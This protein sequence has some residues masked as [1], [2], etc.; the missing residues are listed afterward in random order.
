[1]KKLVSLVSLSMVA[2]LFVMTSCGSKQGTPSGIVKAMY[3]QLQKGNYEKAIEIM[4][5][6]ATDKN[7]KADAEQIKESVK[8]FA[9][10]AQESIEEKEGI[11]SFEI[12]KETVA[13]DGKSAQVTVKVT[14]GDGSTKEDTNKFVKNEAG[15]W[16]MNIFNK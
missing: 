8:A 13:E 7:E 11:R 9:A 4:F 10:K 12:V 16:E 14:Y 15:K 3:G 1:M 6:N 5:E 2:F